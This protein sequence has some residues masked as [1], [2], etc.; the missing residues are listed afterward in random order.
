MSDHETIRTAL[1]EVLSAMGV[2]DAQIP[3]NWSEPELF[4]FMSLFVVAQVAD[5]TYRLDDGQGGMVIITVLS[6]A[7]YLAVLSPES[8]TGSGRSGLQCWKG[9]VISEGP[10][11]K[12]IRISASSTLRLPTP[13]LIEAPPPLNFGFAWFD[14][15]E[16]PSGDIL[17]V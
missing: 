4:K 8:N 1:T 5:D 6:V 15:D 16:M 7:G 2:D 14:F 17:R 9:G 10:P 3:R 13:S 12:R 11:S